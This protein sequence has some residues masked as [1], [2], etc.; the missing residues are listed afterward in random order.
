VEYVNNPGASDL[1]SADEGYNIGF[2]L[3]DAKLKHNWQL[4][5]NYKHIGAAA[6]WHGLNDDDF[7][8]NAKGGTGVAGHQVIASYHAFEP[9]WMNVRF[10]QTEQINQPPEI[11]SEQSRVFLDLL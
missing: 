8:V 11:S 2:T 3:G 5:Y 7:G 1:G 10:M 6:V 4:S 9:F